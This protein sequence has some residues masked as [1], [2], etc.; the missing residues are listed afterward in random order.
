[1]VTVGGLKLWTSSS[2]HRIAGEIQHYKLKKWCTY[3]ELL[4]ASNLIRERKIQVFLLHCMETAFEWHPII[5]GRLIMSVGMFQHMSDICVTYRLQNV[6]LPTAQN[7]PAIPH[8][9][10]NLLLQ[11]VSQS[12]N[13]TF[14]FRP[15]LYLEPKSEAHLVERQFIIFWGC[16][17]RTNYPPVQ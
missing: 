5:L 7:S 17:V 13:F 15:S 4:K 2:L 14:F 6:K 1:M 10:Q 8:K 16:L 11:R 9:L 3:M 12:C